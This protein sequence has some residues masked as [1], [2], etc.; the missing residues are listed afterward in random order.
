MKKATMLALRKQRK[1]GQAVLLSLAI[2]TILAALIG[3]SVVRTSGTARIASRAAEYAEAERVSDGLIEYAY[4][5][6]KGRTQEMNNWLPKFETQRLTGTP[7][8][9]GG[10][11]HLDLAGNNTLSILP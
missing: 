11:T 1:S 6:W 5:V 3:T 4:G 7:P 2:I 10:F 9:F 8:N